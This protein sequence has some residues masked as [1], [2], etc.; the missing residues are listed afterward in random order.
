MR[1]DVVIRFDSERPMAT[2]NGTQQ[3]PT[4]APL[5]SLREPELTPA[6]IANLEAFADNMALLWGTRHDTTW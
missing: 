4:P 2:R 5:S 3:L 6:E 1:S